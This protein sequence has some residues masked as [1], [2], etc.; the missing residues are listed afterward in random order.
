M[1]MTFFEAYYLAKSRPMKAGFKRGG[2][3]GILFV[4]ETGNV[5]SINDAGDMIE[6][7]IDKTELYLKD[8]CVLY[9]IGEG[10]ESAVPK[11]KTPA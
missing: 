10:E 5:V 2:N 6:A 8:W 11:K 3:N 1:D 7:K 4:S 9:G